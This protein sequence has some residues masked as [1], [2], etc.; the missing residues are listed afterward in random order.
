MEPGSQK[1]S[2]GHSMGIVIAIK[3]TASETGSILM[4]QVI[5]TTSLKPQK[6]YSFT[7]A[8]LNCSQGVSLD[9]ISR[10]VWY[11]QSEVS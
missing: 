4:V 10:Q 5:K 9:Q 2:N 3:I 8:F 6:V 1:I 11:F 7:L